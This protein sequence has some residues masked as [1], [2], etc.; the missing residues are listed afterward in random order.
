[1][2][3]AL[4]SAATALVER[5]RPGP[6]YTA[7]WAHGY[8]DFSVELAALEAAL[9]APQGEPS[10]TITKIEAE[11]RLRVFVRENIQ[12]LFSDGGDKFIATTVDALFGPRR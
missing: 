1:M 3:D 8:T 7:S 9:A 6:T 5:L 11:A 2:T 12:V 4:R 10:E